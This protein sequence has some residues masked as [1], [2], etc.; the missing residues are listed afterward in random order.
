MTDLHAEHINALSSL[1]MARMVYRRLRHRPDLIDQIAADLE[2]AIKSHAPNTVAD[3]THEW[4]QGLRDPVKLKK[5]MTGSGEH[6]LW[7]RKS[8]PFHGSAVGL[9]F[10]DVAW[11]KRMRQAARRIAVKEVQPGRIWS[12]CGFKMFTA[13]PSPEGSAEF[14]SIAEIG[15]IIGKD[16]VF[17]LRAFEARAISSYRRSDVERYAARVINIPD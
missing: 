6:D 7:L 4:L 2:A 10:T 3:Y 11:R 1:I 8:R 15:E 16:G 17:V 12:I 13:Y 14:C 5:V 9:D